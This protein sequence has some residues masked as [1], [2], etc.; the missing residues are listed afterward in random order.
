M[1][2]NKMG[3]TV[4]CGG[5]LTNQDRVLDIIKYG[6]V[7][8]FSVRQ[9][10]LTYDYGEI[11]IAVKHWGTWTTLDG[12]DIDDEVEELLARK[13]AAKIKALHESIMQERNGN[14]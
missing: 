12:Y 10:W 8:K 4:V 1:D 9:K 7:N 14:D 2:L 6:N 3:C 5:E 13:K 11:S